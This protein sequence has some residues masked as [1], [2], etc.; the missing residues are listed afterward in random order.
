MQGRKKQLNR[1]S[2]RHR[3]VTSEERC[4]RC[5]TSAPQTMK[6]PFARFGGKTMANTCNAGA[7]NALHCIVHPCDDDSESGVGW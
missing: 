3:D 4:H 5:M 1:S 2:V 6:G 7:D